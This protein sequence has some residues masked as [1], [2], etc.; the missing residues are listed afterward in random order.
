MRRQTA[1]SGINPAG[2]SRALRL[3]P[4]SLPL[5]FDAH[6]TRADGSVR[7]IELHRE[8]VVL[9]RAVQGMR[10]AVNIRVSDFLGVGLAR[11]RRRAGADA[12]ASRSLAFDSAAGLFR[13]RRDRI[14]LADLERD[15]RASAIAGRQGFANPP[16]AAAATTPSAAAARNSWCAAAPATC[17]TR[18]TFTPA[19]ARSSQGIDPT[20]THAVVIPRAGGGSSTLQPIDLII[21]ISGILDRP[22]KPGDDSGDCS[23]SASRPKFCNQPCPR[24]QRA[25]GRPGARRTRGL[26]GC[27]KKIC[28][29]RAYRFS[30]EP[31][32]FPAQWLYGLYEIVLVTGFLATIASFG[33]R[34]RQ[35]DASTGASDPNDF[36]VRKCRARQSQHQR[37]SLPAPRLRRWPT[38]LWW[39]RMA[40]VMAVICPTGPAIYFYA[41]GWTGFG[42]LPV[43]L[44]C[45]RRQRHLLVAGARES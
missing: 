29:L 28:C 24:N 14:R 35:L 36:A 44:L 17:S 22:V 15:L 30:G 26:A 1:T 31:P 2:S 16:P 9:R 18:R 20:A 32:A 19:N 27:C 13:C 12:G 34:F 8:R 41:K 42:D 38:P 43:G 25:Q 7:K 40:G 33:F 39:D 3:D 6:D 21:S 23:R 37:P 10:M 5:R 11:P 45:R 4:L